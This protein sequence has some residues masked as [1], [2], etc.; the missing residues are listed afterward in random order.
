MKKITINFTIAIVRKVKVIDI[1]VIN[2]QKKYMD[3]F[4]KK[5]KI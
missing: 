3:H 4:K 2:T 1:K 5:Y